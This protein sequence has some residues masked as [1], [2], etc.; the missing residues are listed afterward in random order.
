V[1]RAPWEVTTV[2]SCLPVAIL[3]M[4]SALAHLLRS[5]AAF[6]GAQIQAAALQTGDQKLAEQCLPDCS[7]PDQ[8]G[9]GRHVASTWPDSGSN[10]APTQ[11]HDDADGATRDLALSAY[12]LSA[13][14]PARMRHSEA[15]TAAARV[16]SSPLAWCFAVSA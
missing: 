8:P 14:P 9:M 7:S 10:A 5:D 1:T 12:I 11:H 16:R 6:A 2:V 13:R 4:G 15:Y 3:G